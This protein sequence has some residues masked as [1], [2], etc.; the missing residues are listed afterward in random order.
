[1]KKPEK[2]EVPEC[3][4]DISVGDYESAYNEGRNEMEAYYKQEMK[5]YIRKDELPSYIDIEDIIR[6]FDLSIMEVIDDHVPESVTTCLKKHLGDR[7]CKNIARV[8]FKSIKG[9]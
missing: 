2:K 1:V 6:N 5:N 3:L 7:A 4:N 9:K 8:I